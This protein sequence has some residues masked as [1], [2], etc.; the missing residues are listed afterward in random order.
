MTLFERAVLYIRRKKGKSL[1][2]FFI[3]LLVSALLLT[4]FSIRGA[5]QSTAYH[6]RQS[7][8]GS[9]GLT[10]DKSKS[11]HFQP[12]KDGKEGQEGLE[13]VGKPISDEVVKQI[14]SLP[15][16]RDFNA[17]QVGN[18]ILQGKDA[19][20]LELVKTNTDY[21]DGDP[22]LHT[23]TGESD[24]ASKYSSYFEQ[25][26]FKLTQG[27]HLTEQDKNAALI[28]EE[29]ADLNHLKVGD[30]IELQ[31]L[32]N[33]T[34]NV[35]IRLKIKGI[36]KIL[37]PQASTAA[38]PP[39]S[40]YQNRIFID[41][42]SGNALYAPNGSSY[43]RADFY[44]ND[45]AKM[46]ETMKSVRKIKSIP[47]DN[48]SITANDAK[49]QKAA[50]PLSSMN[51]LIE[52]MLMT[53]T[54][55]GICILSLL[56]TLWMRSRVH[57]TG[58]LLSIGIPKGRIVLQH[59]TEV[60]SLTFA[61]FCLAFLISEAAVQTFGKALLAGSMTDKVRSVSELGSSVTLT[62]AL[63]VL[64]LGALAGIVSVGV[65]SISILRLKPKEILTKM[66]E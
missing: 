59:M 6:L 21:A 42:S 14:A 46:Q 4:G 7:L 19:A 51:A 57:E 64:G 65:S 8:G 20:P 58:I 48:F 25:E 24:T 62:D 16:I 43:N 33:N 10:I 54:I 56:L 52:T 40:L 47:W 60:L 31:S 23:F 18:G 35:P 61:A 38:L 5:F 22:I 37:K 9:F 26:I 2:L 50:K 11:D 12:R 36:F 17:S 27:K 28:S 30:E 34:A 63:L 3:L 53:V 49:Y 55:S 15:E 32:D 44:V 39:P 66:S 13:Y 41:N 29:L 1:I 45:P